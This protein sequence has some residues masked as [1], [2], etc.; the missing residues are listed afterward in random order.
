MKRK[1]CTITWHDASHVSFEGVFDEYTSFVE[2]VAKFPDEVW[3]DFGK[4]TRVNSLGVKEWVKAITACKSRMHYVNCPAIIVDQFNM[5]TNFLSWNTTVDSFEVYFVCNNCDHEESRFFELG[6]GKEVDP[7]NPNFES[8]F[9]CKC[10][11]CGHEMELDHDPDIY[12]S[13]I[14]E[15]SRKK[16]VG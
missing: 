2:V 7:E 13:F 4:V 14:H 12:F 6:Q 9:E 10:I 15:M 5:I 8:S 3:L 16:S 11:R 1:P